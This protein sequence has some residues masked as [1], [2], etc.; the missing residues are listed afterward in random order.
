MDKLKAIWYT[1]F[2]VL[3]NL[4]TPI[5]LEWYC[6]YVECTGSLPPVGVSMTLTI[7]WC[8]QIAIGVILWNKALNPPKQN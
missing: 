4:L 6:Q 3:E 7:L 8:G 5:F 2:F 1:M